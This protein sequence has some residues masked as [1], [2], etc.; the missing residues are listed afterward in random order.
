MKMKPNLNL[1]TLILIILLIAVGLISSSSVFAANTPT[2]DV[3]Y[4]LNQS[5]GDIGTPQSHIN[6][7]G[8]VSDP[9]GLDTNK[10]TFTLNGGSSQDYK[11]GPDNRR[12]AEAGDFN[13]DI[14]NSDLLDGVNTL[15][16]TA[17]DTLNNPATQ[18]VTINFTNS[19]S[20][21]TSYTADWSLASEISDVAQV[22]DGSWQ[23]TGGGVR[24]TV[25]DYDRLIAIGDVSWTDYTVIVPV[26]IHGLDT[27]PGAYQAPSNFPGIGLITHWQG[28]YDQFGSQPDWG[29]DNIGAFGLYLVANSQHRS[30][31][32]YCV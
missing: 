31:S 29:W 1:T 15:E 21:P 23:L 27:D 3:W 25:L 30:K 20:W 18:T 9:D 13:I 8:N 11:I 26:T 17:V 5:F 16:I 19:N 24:P 22:V 12:L 10:L 7:F 32:A 6:I 14:P 28:H 4:G 2:I